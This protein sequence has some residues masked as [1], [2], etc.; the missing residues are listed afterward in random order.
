MAI[1]KLR[2][3]YM[4]ETGDT[5]VYRLD[6]SKFGLS[7][8]QS[9][10]IYDD[11]IIS[12]GR[13]SASG[14]DLD[15][16]KTSTTKASF[17]STTATLAGDAVFNFTSGVQYRP[18]FMQPNASSDPISWKQPNLEGTTAGN[19]YS[20]GLATFGFLDGVNGDGNGSLSLGEGGQ[21]TFKLTSSITTAGRYLYIG[22][23]GGG[24]DD[25]YV[26][27]SSDPEGPADDGVALTGTSSDDQ[28]LLGSGN[29]TGLGN[30]DDYVDGSGG[31]DNISTGAGTDTIVGNAGNDT[32]NG[33]LDTDTAVYKGTRSQYVIS[34]SGATTTVTGNNEGFDTLTNVEFLKFSDQLYTILNPGVNRGGTAGADVLL[35][36]EKDDTAVGGSGNDYVYCYEGRDWAYGGDGVDVLLGLGGNDVL[37]GDGG[38]DYL[39][40]GNGNDTMYG[41]TGVDVFIGGTGADVMI[42]EADG[43]YFY[44]EAGNN[45]YFGGDGNDIF[46]GGAG[47][48]VF[49]CGNGNDFV[50]AGSGADTLLGGEGVDVLLG[51]GGND[52]FDAGSGTDY[53]FLGTGGNDI[54]KVTASSGVQVVFDFAAGGVEDSIQLVGTPLTTFAQVK[55][56]TYDYG[57]FSIV[58]VDADTAIWLIGVSPSQMTA[59]D[60]SFA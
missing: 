56:N 30:G 42:G 15:F 41:G 24:N 22:D 18:G 44:G 26:S 2:P 60:F 46:V 35:G 54:V 34:T 39:Y 53:L 47:D 7:S 45:L 23:V 58:Q 13:G 16:I 33:G 9:I 38:N 1:L 57:S 36:A 43:D 28:I 59:A 40:G 6:L 19:V 51:Q 32:I 14:F 17:S 27:V 5:G 49:D 52:F 48:E 31:N 21:V 10:T 20:P 12:G 29:N 50:Y 3:E 8:I 11:N 55:A 25:V 37:L 4:G